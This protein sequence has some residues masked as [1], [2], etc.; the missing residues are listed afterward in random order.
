[1]ITTQKYNTLE[2][3]GIKSAVSFGIK[4][5]GLAH[6]F[7]VLRNQLYTNKIGA[8]VREYSANAYDANVEAGNADKS[9]RITLPSPLD[10]TFK[11][12]DFGR[13]LSQDDIQEIYCFYGES[14]KRQ[15]N[16]Y[17]GQ[18]GLGSKSAFAYG[19]NFLINSYTD[20]KLTSYNAFIDPSGIGQIAMLSQKDTDEANGVEIC[21][22]VRGEDCRE[23][24][25]SVS[26]YLRYFKTK[27]E[28]IGMNA[29]ELENMFLPPISSGENWSF[30]KNVNVPHAIMGNIA[31]PLSVSSMKLDHSRDDDQKIYNVLSSSI[32][33]NF[34]IG[35][36]DVAA[37]R[38]GLQYTDRTLQSIRKLTLEVANKIVADIEKNIGSS[39]KS[40]FG[41]K[42]LLYSMDN[43]VDGFYH[44]R[45]LMNKITFKGVPITNDHAETGKKSKDGL[46]GFYCMRYEKNWNGNVR[47]GVTDSFQAN[48][49]AILVFNDMGNYNTGA[50]KARY[51]VSSKSD[52]ERV[53]LFTPQ[54]RKITNGVVQDTK[55][56]K[57]DEFATYAAQIEEIKRLNGYCDDDFILASSIV[58]PANV[59]GTTTKTARTG[60][61]TFDLANSNHYYNRKG[62]QEGKIDMKGGTGIYIQVN[63]YQGVLKDGKVGNSSL[64]NLINKFPALKGQTIVGVT[65]TQI[66]SL[67]SGWVHILDAMTEEFETFVKSKGINLDKTIA[68]RLANMLCRDLP[69]SNVRDSKNQ[70][71]LVAGLKSA[72]MSQTMVAVFDAMSGKAESPA[73]EKAITMYDALVPYNKIQSNSVSVKIA[74]EIHKNGKEL[75][76]RFPLLQNVEWSAFRWGNSDQA[77]KNLLDYFNR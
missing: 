16:A 8:V 42:K 51:L 15:S 65:G 41:A 3:A 71:S 55:A 48:G 37:S 33:L 56:I 29:S 36:L 66:K 35:D 40:V 11:V 12:R 61:L 50:S 28:I 6:I 70:S 52:N 67:G 1:M 58:I 39:A 60:V 76:K 49:R 2:S 23:F 10:K 18:L 25:K 72:S 32:V 77:V 59:V 5:S 57:A 24:E 44:L 64:A 63:N 22:P 19:D 14:T 27:A 69:I 17:I 9:I 26:Q 45:K 31:Y 53:Y 62:W 20:G 13:G 47:A 43:F 54:V 4:D 7:N 34:Q 21:I 73:A 38:E 30:Y 68:N 74:E 46:V 75:C